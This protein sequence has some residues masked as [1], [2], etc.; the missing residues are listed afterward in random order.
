MPRF[1]HTADWQLGR[2]YSR[3]D[4]D[5][6]VALMEARFT[7][8]ERIAQLAVGKQVDAVLV[9][10]DIFDAQGLADATL[11]RAFHALSAFAGPW[12]LLP[13]NHDAALSES[14]WRRAE[15]LGAITA[16]VHVLTE[17]R[18][19]CFEALNTAILPAPLTQ[20]QTLQD[21]T[22]WF[23]TA[24]TPDGM[25][26]IG[27]AHGSVTGALTDLNAANPIAADRA[28]TARLDYLALGDWH[29]C[30][31][32]DTHTW[33]SGTP[34]PDRFKDNGAGHVLLVEA[35]VGGTPQVSVHA[36]GQHQWLQWHRELAGPTDLERLFDEFTTLAPMSVIDL[37]VS[38]HIDLN[39]RQR[40]EQT[41]GALRGRH[42][43]VHADLDHL[44][45]APT[46][47]D[48]ASLHANGYVGDV[49]AEL[50]HRQSSSTDADV[51][52]EALLILAN[53]LRE[54]QS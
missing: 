13:G 40:L 7:T 18:V 15:R 26:R 34:E 42:R 9:A 25:L 28:R 41:L 12:I 48:L 11:F 1:L 23:D 6:A 43:S 20:R 22:A 27:L 39:G 19:A 5:D 30:K 2:R 16:N 36:I 31:A 21:L 8:V 49:L 44:N 14:I 50:Q 3:F 17:A 54:G 38:G 45:L 24:Q 53:T 29:G 10:G 35:E 46:A 33:Y 37:E 32:I 47:D 51:A 4:P 52:R